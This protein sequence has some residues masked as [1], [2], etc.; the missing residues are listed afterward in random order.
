VAYDRRE[1]VVELGATPPASAPTLS[2][3]CVFRR[4]SSLRLRSVIVPIYSLTYSAFL[5]AFTA[6]PGTVPPPGPF[7]PIAVFREIGRMGAANA[8]EAFA[9]FT[10]SRSAHAPRLLGG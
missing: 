8:A 4:T 9:R 7:D 3:F 1:Q 2:T 5:T 6:R 10:G